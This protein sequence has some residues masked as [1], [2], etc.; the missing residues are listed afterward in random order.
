M[1]RNDQTGS[2]VRTGSEQDTMQSRG[3]PGVGANGRQAYVLVRRQLWGRN[4]RRE[5]KK[6][7]ETSR[8]GLLASCLSMLQD[9]W[10]FLATAQKLPWRSSHAYFFFL[11]KL[12]SFFEDSK[13]C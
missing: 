6:E 13:V 4:G 2:G 1:K 12:P 7:K 3:L 9:V 8:A 10:E 5:K 11:S